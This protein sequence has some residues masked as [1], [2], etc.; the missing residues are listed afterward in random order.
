MRPTP[1]RRTVK[2]AKKPTRKSREKKLGEGLFTDVVF[3]DKNLI[4]EAEYRARSETMSKEEAEANRSWWRQ[5]SKSATAEANAEALDAVLCCQLRTRRAVERL[6]NWKHT[7]VNRRG[8]PVVGQA[9][10]LP[11]NDGLGLDFSFM[12]KSPKAQ[13]YKAPVRHLFDRVVR[14]WLGGL[15][16]GNHLSA[17]TKEAIDTTKRPEDYPVLA[18]ELSKLKD[19]R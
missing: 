16:A 19:R 13:E 15:P 8:G 10:V 2:R 7:D 17:L 18:P 12:T 14:A 6:Q 3:G 9:S 4:G 1:K 11:I 5:G